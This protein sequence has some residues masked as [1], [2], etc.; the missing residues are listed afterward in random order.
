MDEIVPRADDKSYADL[1][2]HISDRPGHDLRYAVDTT[3]IKA[4]IDWAP[5]QD[6]EQ[7]LARTVAWFVRDF[8][9]A[10]N[11]PAFFNRELVQFFI[12]EKN[13]AEI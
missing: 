10:D 8:D 12:T 3:K 13:I 2:E 11:F 9:A 5:E 6:F 4:T 7:G 1:I